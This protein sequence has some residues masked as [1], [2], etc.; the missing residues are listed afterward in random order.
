MAHD[1]S[2]EDDED[3][4]DSEFDADGKEK[5]PVYHWQIW[6]K[7]LR[8]GSQ[9]GLVR[10]GLSSCN[11][12]KHQADQ[13]TVNQQPQSGDHPLDVTAAYSRQMHW[14]ME[15]RVHWPANLTLWERPKPWNNPTYDVGVMKYKGHVVLD[16]T[17]SPIRNFRI[18]LTISSKIDGL[19]IESWMRA[20]D[21]LTLSDIAARLWTKDKADGGKMPCFDRRALSKRASLARCRAGLISWLPK[22]GRDAQTEFMDSL[23]TPEQRAQN[24]ATDK[25]LT[26]AQQ[27]TYA[28]IGLNENKQSNAPTRQERIRK[29]KKA[30]EKDTAPGSSSAATDPV[31]EAG[32][33]DDNVTDVGADD[34][35]AD[36]EAQLQRQAS[37]ED[38]DDDS[39]ISSG[40]L[41]PD[42]SR[43]DRPTNPEDEASL[44][45]ALE[46]TREDFFFLTGQQPPPTDPSENYFSQWGEL[47][48]NFRRLW[49]ARGNGTDGPRLRSRDRWTGGISQYE[50]AEIVEGSLDSGQAQGG[51]A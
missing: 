35:E 10:Y 26:T 11:F 37:E 46:I 42:D 18:P 2:E 40:L 44:Q 48:G 23:R 21:R 17:G 47:Q 38:S 5:K 20:D 15:N 7:L 51:D 33:E 22:K 36:V 8:E 49:E 1:D 24:R 50:F 3:E 30:A 39:S 19:R 25:S 27:A 12:S 28:K 9:G 29:I 6:E 43:N 31:A 14:D 32:G 41:D 4:G 45:S 34:D 16:T 13:D